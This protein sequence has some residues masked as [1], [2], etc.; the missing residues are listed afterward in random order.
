MEIVREALEPQADR[1]ATTT[2]QTEIS[3]IGHFVFAFCWTSSEGQRRR[4]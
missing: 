3:I 2:P 1:H 4:R